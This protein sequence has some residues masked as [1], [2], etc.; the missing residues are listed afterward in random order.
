LKCD[1]V[2]FFFGTTCSLYHT[3]IRRGYK[4]GHDPTCIR[5]V[6]YRQ[7]SIQ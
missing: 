2:A 6:V 1:V 3:K 4:S 7:Q 5:L